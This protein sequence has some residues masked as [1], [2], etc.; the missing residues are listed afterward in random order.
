[1]T[2]LLFL[3]QQT[4]PQTL[5]YVPTVAEVGALIR[6]RTKDTAG[7]EL[8][9]FT[10][11][12][13]PTGDQAEAESLFAVDQVWGRLGQNPEAAGITAATTALFPQARRAAAIY[14]AMLIELSYFPEQ[15]QDDQS[16]YDRLKELY[17][18]AIANLAA[19]VTT[20]PA[21]IQGIG[22]IAVAS[23]VVAPNPLVDILPDMSL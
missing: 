14:A 11:A 16:P 21:D 3:Q 1:M 8:G 20:D 7:N 19:S 4:D 6:A 17:D 22:M 5:N 18:Q 23:T 9:T 2:L 12:T 13:R 15:I 10:D